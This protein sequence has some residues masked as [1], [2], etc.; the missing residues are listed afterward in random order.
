MRT[1]STLYRSL[2][3]GRVL[4][5][6]AFAVVLAATIAACGGSN[7]EAVPPG[8][9]TA[10]IGP[11]GATLD[12][13]NGAR[14]VVPANALAQPTSISIANSAAGAP[15]LP[16]GQVVLGSTFALTPHG[17]TFAQA[18]TLTVP[19]DPSRVPAGETPVLMKTNAAQSGWDVVPGAT[20]SGSAM[21][22]PIGSFSFVVIVLPLVPPTIRT[23]PLPQSVVAP[24]PATFA[25]FATGPTSSGILSF[26]WRRNGVNITGANRASYT[27]DPTSVAADDGAIYSVTVTNLAGP[28]TSA[29]ALLTVT[30]GIVAPLITQQ[31]VDLSVA[32]GA[33][34]AF[35]AVATGT[36]PIYQ[37]ERSD[38]PGLPFV[39]INGANAPTYT[40]AAVAAADHNA[41]FQLRVSN[42]AGAVTSNIATLTV[43]AVPPPSRLGRIAAG[44]SFSLAV[45]AAGVPYSW[46]NDSA[47]QLGNGAPDANRNTAA[48]FG[49]LTDVRS[50][51]AGQEYHGIAVRNDGTA[52][53]WGYRG[54]V[55]CA[56][57]SVASTPFKVD[58]AIDILAA[59]AGS[60]H[61]LLLR[62]DGHVL[63]FGC[64]HSG[65]LGRPGLT[66]PMTPLAIVQGLA[67]NI[68]AVAAGNAFS[69]ALD[70]NGD[71]WS[72]GRSN[73]ADFSG[74]NSSPTPVRLAGLS[75]VVAIAAANGHALA[76]RRDGA[77]F[78]WGSN[79]NGK[80]GD[81]TEVD[82]ALPTPTLLTSQITAIAAGGNHSLALRA[83][84]VVMAWGINET[85]QP[86]SGS[87]PGAVT[88]LADVVAIAAGAGHS[89]AL[90]RNGSVWAWGN[91]NVGQL[92]D[93]TNTS[94]LAPVSV[95]GLNLN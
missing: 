5:Q 28:V 15:A 22:A 29:D 72:W 16:A 37:W 77:V 32:V 38:A 51:S 39:A 1:E 36:A 94:R 45:N 68:V 13:P 30:P 91:N 66:P 33:S 19:F 6:A 40:I 93:G 54:S 35:A 53:A 90:Q 92:G 23:Q 64:N 48:P 71:V 14:L 62:S 85:G 12:G 44:G 34:A 65:Q 47:S 67:T 55:D 25:A 60:D 8:A 83:D 87:A 11:A 24:A 70:A 80:L 42:A 43:T 20:V 74:N 73:P 50:V 75:N 63:S 41:R 78:A 2:A 79:A 86:G 31:P 89:L 3:C 95:V 7:D 88:G 27:T 49:T 58:Y 76:L 81:G 82:R 17:T 21:Q 9:A 59:S 26:Q 46:G 10:M 69:L 56:V 18:A 52:W 4:A 61:T 84:G 57:G